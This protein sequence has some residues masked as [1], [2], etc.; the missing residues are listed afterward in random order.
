M[1]YSYDL[2]GTPVVI[3]FCLH[4]LFANKSKKKTK[5]LKDVQ[6]FSFLVPVL[7]CLLA[8]SDIISQHNVNVNNKK[9]HTNI[10]PKLW[11]NN[12]QISHKVR[13]VPR[14]R[15]PQCRK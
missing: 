8:I 13:V 15:L 1:N 9:T 7:L 10:A 2:F 5:T 12:I 4:K 11:S 14:R 3:P 6:P